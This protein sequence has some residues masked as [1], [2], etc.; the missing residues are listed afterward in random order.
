[1]SFLDAIIWNNVTDYDVPSKN[2]EAEY[3]NV[4]VIFLFYVQ[5]IK[6]IKG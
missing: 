3:L 1:M 6:L 5:M 4:I 2:E